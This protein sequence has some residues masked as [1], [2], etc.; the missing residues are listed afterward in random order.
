MKKRRVKRIFEII[1]QITAVVLFVTLIVLTFAMIVAF[2]R[3]SLTTGN[4]PFD[5]DLLTSSKKSELSE[6]DG[7]MLPELVGLSVDG[8]KY[9]ISASA[10]IVS[11]LYGLIQP[12]LSEMISEE[13]FRKVHGE[14]WYEYT[15]ADEFVYVR[16]HNELPDNIIALF[17]DSAV[18]SSTGEN[19]NDR[20][21]VLTY[22]CELVLMPTDA[23]GVTRIATRSL[24]GDVTVY[25][26]NEASFDY[27]RIADTAMSYRS[28]LSR[29]VFSGD[30]YSSSLDTEP[31]F[32]DSISTRDIMLSSDTG[33]LVFNNESYKE[34]L[35]RLFSINPDK[36]LSEH[37]DAS[38]N[39]S[40][41][42]VHGV[43]YLRTR[44][45]EYHGS[46]DGG[47]DIS[48]YIGYTKGIGLEEYIRASVGIISE[49]KAINKY[50]IGNDADPMLYSVESSGGRVRLTF[51]YTIDN[52]LVTGGRHAFVA[53]FENGK[54][55]YADVC[56]VAAKNLIT[57]SS[58][59]SESWFIKSLGEGVVPMNVSL[60]Y[61]S[62]YRSSSVSAKWAAFVPSD[63]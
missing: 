18:Y 6:I 55:T 49:I 62:D 22:V 14:A 16:Y 15:G 58:S 63:E 35:M 33:F 57:R 44:G 50:F 2:S 47:V 17:A 13:N 23:R 48:E 36:L 20:N 59:Y 61:E 5:L 32:L 52:I 54:L 37:E 12:A 40:Y 4:V 43:L 25:E 3:S 39:I 19:E 31:V 8:E 30:V 27:A 45:F 42:D 34:S 38:G 11:E 41:T 26:S 53:E 56:A 46:P 29:F 10:N 7:Y 24:D 9:A 1:V 60:V 21:H 51:E 28:S